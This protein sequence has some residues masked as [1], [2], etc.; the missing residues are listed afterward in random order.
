MKKNIFLYL[1]LAFAIQQ[2]RAQTLKVIDKTNLQPIS[3]VN[4]SDKGAQHQVFT[5]Q[6]G[7]ADLS[8]FNSNDTL[9]FQHPAYN[10]RLYTYNDLSLLNFRVTLS[11][12]LYSL[13]EAVISASRFEEKLSDVA[14]QVQVLKAKDL[15]FLSQPSSADVLQSSGNVLVQ[16]SQLGGGSPIIRG[17]ETNK[18]LMVVDGVR[19]NNAIY[20]GGHI[21]NVLSIDNAMLEKVEVVFG[22]GS[23]VYGSDALGGVMHFYSKNPVLS[24][25]AVLRTNGNAFTRF[26]T[27]SSENTGHVDF[28]ISG[29]RY[30]SLTSI[31]YSDFGDLRQ[32]AVRNPFYVNWG[33]SW[34]YADRVGGRDTMIVS[35]DPNIQR[36]SAYGQ[37][38]VLQK[39]LYKQNHKVTHLL[40]LQY[41]SSTNIPRY[42]RL[43]LLQNGKPRFAEWYYGPQNRFFAAYTLELAAERMFYDHARII[44][45]YQNIEESRHDRNFNS[46]NLNHRTEQL[47]IVSLNADFTKKIKR[48]ELRFGLDSWY[49]LVNSTAHRENINTAIS[50]P[51]DTRY[52]SGGSAMM[53]VASYFTHSYEL[54]K[55]LIVNDGIRLSNVQLEAAF[56]DTTF[57]RFPFKSVRQ[58]NS[59]LNGNL[60]L[61]YMP[62]D[63][64]RFTV[65]ASSGFRA[66]N[67]DDLSKV[68]ESVPGRVIV[69]NAD[70][71]PE[72]TYNADIGISKVVAGKITL[73]ATGFYTLY[74]DAITTL[75]G[76]FN[77]KDSIIYGGN[78]SRVSKN[79][80][81]NN[82]YIYGFNAFLHAEI[83][84]NFSISNTLNY[85]FGRIRTD[86]VDYPLD[87]MPPV[88]GRTAFQLKLSKF[89]GDFFVMYNGAKR[90]KD[91]N[92]LGEDNHIYSADPKR[93]FMPAWLTL[94]LRT[95]YQF[96]K[97]VQVQLAIENI[98]DQN[99][100]VF[101][102]NISAPGRNFM[103]TLRGMF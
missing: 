38:D 39:F 28:N 23:V 100:R 31:T 102:S 87:H 63:G 57:Y 97:N 95:A 83:N 2:Y 49:N 53:S 33:K 1:A 4:I 81:A 65:L 98:L 80:N 9:L 89:R 14:Q 51:L 62:G 35:K 18:V 41:S 58:N 70:L 36:P 15:A 92:L 29:K 32:G 76:T 86:T 75:P 19:L 79:V 8:R 91:Y 25:T 61:V 67:V 84:D 48:H 21:H 69:P 3:Q 26:S 54:S 22:P 99:Y 27:A 34:F 46:P 43:S 60:G 44:I 24:D 37:Y 47:D 94:N 66:P 101:A 82:A 74:K 96:N 73:G 56:S 71:R 77:D 17:F 78:L 11:E 64:W 12:K 59:A 85:T 6:F 93:G 45:A 20:R 72:Y 50:T 68:F 88:F 13:D 7:K 52:P 40:N 103:L 90:A 55:K 16:K 5:N 10:N 42:D 30:G